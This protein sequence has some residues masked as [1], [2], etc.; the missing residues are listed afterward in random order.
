[1][2]FKETE[3]Y[4]KYINLIHILAVAPLLGYIGYNGC[5]VDPKL[6]QALIVIA[7][8]IIV[9]HSY[10]FFKRSNKSIKIKVEDED[11]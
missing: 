7:L 2:Q 11:I 5:K 6:F 4:Y 8:V 9:Y 1:M 3:E 10:R